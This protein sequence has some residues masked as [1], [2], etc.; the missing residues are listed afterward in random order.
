MPPGGSNRMTH[1][2]IQYT[3]VKPSIGYYPSSLVSWTTAE[4]WRHFL[5]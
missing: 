2:F 1:V 3:F 4:R 5:C